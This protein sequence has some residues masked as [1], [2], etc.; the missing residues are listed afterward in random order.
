MPVDT[1][2]LKAVIRHYKQ[3]KYCQCT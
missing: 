1:W 2:S 3:K